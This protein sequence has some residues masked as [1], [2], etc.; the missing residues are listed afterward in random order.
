MR[1]PLSGG[2]P[3]GNGSDRL[4][5]VAQVV[6]S[7]NVNLFKFKHALRAT[8]NHNNKRVCYGNFF[9]WS[10]SISDSYLSSRFQENYAPK[11]KTV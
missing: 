9:Q 3:R 11:S 7:G 6:A 5:G 8:R 2:H 1:E 4:I 10:F